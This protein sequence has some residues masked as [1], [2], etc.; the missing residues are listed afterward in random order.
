M[1]IKFLTQ[2]I[3]RSD[4]VGSAGWIKQYKKNAMECAVQLLWRKVIGRFRIVFE[5]QVCHMNSFTVA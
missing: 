5:M 2:S 3:S 4:F 1:N